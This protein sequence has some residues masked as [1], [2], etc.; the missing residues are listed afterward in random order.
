MP[1]WDGSPTTDPVR[2]G[3]DGVSGEPPVSTCPQ[4]HQGGGRTG[5]P[6]YGHGRDLKRVPGFLP[7]RGPLVE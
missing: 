1:S 7:D 5:V 2:D 3:G 4:I 6:T